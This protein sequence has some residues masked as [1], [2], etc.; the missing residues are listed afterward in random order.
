M[1]NDREFAAGKIKPH[2]SERFSLAR[3]ADAIGHLAARKVMGKVV[4]VI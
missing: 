2:I 4:V 1:H 3:G